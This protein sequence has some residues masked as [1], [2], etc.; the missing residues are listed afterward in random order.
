MFSIVVPNLNEEKHLPMF[1]E[2]LRAQTWKDFDLI[3]VDGGSTDA[4]LA[5]LWCYAKHLDIQ[6]HTC[7]IRNLGV[8]RNVGHKHSKGHVVF[9]GNSDTYFPPNLLEELAFDFQHSPVAAETGRVVPLGTSWVAK[10]AYPAFDLVRWFSTKLKKFRPSGSFI[11]YRRNIYDLV[12]GIPPLPVN[13]DGLFGQK[14]DETGQQTRFRLDLWVGHHVKKFEE[15]GGAHALMFYL[16]VLRNHFPLLTRFLQPI[17]NQ[18]AQV[19]S[20]METQQL[21]F[22]QLLHGFWNWL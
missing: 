7:R 20:H 22:S 14:I 6:I 18:A 15:M 11:C 10:F 2:S 5:I 12:G 21:T 8:V 13:E 4:S 16:Y 17:E 1:L 3:V 19:F 9:Q